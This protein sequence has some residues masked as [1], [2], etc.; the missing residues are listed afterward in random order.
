MRWWK[1]RGEGFRTVAFSFPFPAGVLV[2]GCCLWWNCRSSTS[3]EGEGSRDMAV[4][5]EC[6]YTSSVTRRIQLCSLASWWS[7]AWA[8]SLAWANRFAPCLRP[9]WLSMR[10]ASAPTI[11]SLMANLFSH[12]TCFNTPKGITQSATEPRVATYWTIK[13]SRSNYQGFFL[14]SSYS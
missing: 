10:P 13:N 12:T 5:G 3:E 8:M 7:R 1:G 9:H 2:W 14:L 4:H 6:G 11:L